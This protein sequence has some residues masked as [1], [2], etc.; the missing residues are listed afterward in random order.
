MCCVVGEKKDALDY[1]N[2]QLTEINMTIRRLRGENSA[3]EAS[4]S[5]TSAFSSGL[6]YFS[7]SASQSNLQNPGYLP[8]SPHSPLPS[9]SSSETT[10]VDLGIPPERISNVSAMSEEGIALSVHPSDMSASGHT[11][12]QTLFHEITKSAPIQTMSGWA[13]MAVQ[14]SSALYDR[15]EMPTTTGFVTFSSRTVG[16]TMILTLV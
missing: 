4:G 2:I 14:G 9:N 12:N 6:P 16:I 10:L 3:F 15:N 8:P 1:Y 5:G 11:E 13:A 7:H